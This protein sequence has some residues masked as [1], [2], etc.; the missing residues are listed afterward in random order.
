MECNPT[1]SFPYLRHLSR[2]C[3]TQQTNNVP[4]L[5][6][7]YILRYIADLAAGPQ[8]ILTLSL[9][10]AT[11]QYARRKDA[12]EEQIAIKDGKLEITMPIS[13][14]Q[15]N[16]QLVPIRP[17]SLKP[18]SSRPR[19]SKIMR[20]ANFSTVPPRSNIKKF[21]NSSFQEE[22]SRV[23]TGSYVKLE[24]KN[25]PRGVNK[26][27]QITSTVIPPAIIPTTVISSIAPTVSQVATP[28]IKVFP[29]EKT[30]KIINKSKIGNST[31]SKAI[32]PLLEPAE[33]IDESAVESKVDDNIE[34]KKKRK[35]EVEIF[36]NDEQ[37]PEDHK[38]RFACPICN[39]CFARKFNMQTHKATHEVDRVKP[40]VCNYP[41]C[42]HSF[43][44]KH[45][46]KRHIYG[47]HELP[48][49]EFKCSNC[50]KTFA[51]KDACK[52][53]SYTCRI[54]EEVP[55]NQ[56]RKHAKTKINNRKKPN[57]KNL[58][59]GDSANESTQ[60]EQQGA[61]NIKEK[62]A[63]TLSIFSNNMATNVAPLDQCIYSNAIKKSTNGNS[64]L[65]ADD[66]SPSTIDDLMDK[67]MPEKSIDQMYEETGENV[68][69]YR[70]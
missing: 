52:R 55:E 34:T 32:N 27:S 51:R 25:F 15:P 33:V 5:R 17:P 41:N 13:I 59:I 57:I 43:T 48:E 8:S 23:T 10:M 2:S 14:R 49:Q 37:E 29:T 16:P 28:A 12:I 66:Y 42:D 58:S 31:D 70:F 65:D 47:I 44:R 54:V 69:G 7:V 9:I 62:T 64:T 45:D 26:S 19:V 1:I 36:T 6:L 38:K 53:H 40:F 35:N 63:D 46:L 11:T 18:E 21:H 67:K 39:R 50:G 56:G 60:D 30:V 3:K 24:T 61:P 22:F 68:Y 4:I 20:H